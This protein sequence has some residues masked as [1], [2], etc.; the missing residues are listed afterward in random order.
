MLRKFIV[1]AKKNDEK[2]YKSN[3]DISHKCVEKVDIFKKWIF[4][5]NWHVTKVDTLEPDVI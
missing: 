5:M 3:V 2:F 4:S 1:S